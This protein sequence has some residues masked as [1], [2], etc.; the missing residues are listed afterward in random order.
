MEF[1]QFCPSARD[2][3][4]SP[5]YANCAQSSRRLRLGD[6]CIVKQIEIFLPRPPGRD[7]GSRLGCG[8][9]FFLSL[10]PFMLRSLLQRDHANLSTTTVLACLL[11]SRFGSHAVSPRCLGSRSCATGSEP[12]GTTAAALPGCCVEGCAE[13]VQKV[14]HFSWRFSF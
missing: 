11:L 4:Q 13:N 8:C 2:I 9:F 12:R 7:E 1:L 10:L 5:F 6:F 14:S 3:S